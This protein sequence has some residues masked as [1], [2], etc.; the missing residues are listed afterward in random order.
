MQSAVAYR[1][2]RKWYFHSEIKTTDGVWVATH[3]FLSSEQESLDVG[4]RAKQ[5]L[6]K[7][8]E[9]VSHPIDW[10]GL[11]TPML[12]LA[13]VKSWSS[14]S[15][16][17]ELV[18]IEMEGNSIKLIPHRNLGPNEGFEP[19][20][21]DAIHLPSDASCEDIGNAIIALATRCLA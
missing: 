1:R 9:G 18:G 17:A 15:R 13:G 19:I 6:A 2:K 10:S 5:A 12:D 21:G 8:T 16:G 20:V 11:F 14:F 3:P 4:D 7:S